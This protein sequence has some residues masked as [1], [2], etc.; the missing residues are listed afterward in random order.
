VGGI[1]AGLPQLLA[2]ETELPYKR[3]SNCLPIQRVAPLISLLQPP[4]Y[5]SEILFFVHRKNFYC[6]KITRQNRVWR[7]I[8]SENLC[9]D[10]GLY[11]LLSKAVL[12]NA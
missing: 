11:F 8:A 7:V 2:A 12:E 9:L 4:E 1:Q 5:K 3:V 10:A 6:R